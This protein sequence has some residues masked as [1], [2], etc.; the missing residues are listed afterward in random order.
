MS[1]PFDMEPS[2][3]PHTRLP[4]INKSPSPNFLDSMKDLVP[5]PLRRS[6]SPL[7][8]SRSSDERN[9]AQPIEM[10]GARAGWDCYPSGRVQDLRQARSVSPRPTYKA[11]TPAPLREPSPRSPRQKYLLVPPEYSTT[12]QVKGLPISAN[13][14]PLLPSSKST[15]T[16]DT[17]RETLR[18]P[19]G[20]RIQI[21]PG[22]R[23]PG[24]PATRQPRRYVPSMIDYLSLEQLENLWESQDLYKGTIDVPQKPTSPLWRLSED[25]PRSPIHPAFRPNFSTQNSFASVVI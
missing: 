10:V 5:A 25:D 2:L 4:A 8:G 16:K 7:L 9:R 12:G 18:S 13:K 21:K 20:A 24:V 17:Y 6:R 14:R 3:R 1:L 11:L 23:A 19:S 15:W 22:V